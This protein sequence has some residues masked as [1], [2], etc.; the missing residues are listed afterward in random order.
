MKGTIRVIVGLFLV[1]GGAG[2][3]ELSS[4]A[5]EYARSLAVA[6]VGL[7]SMGWGVF[8]MNRELNDA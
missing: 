4:N 5:P 2:A 8:A 6:L 3:L 7:A 1:L